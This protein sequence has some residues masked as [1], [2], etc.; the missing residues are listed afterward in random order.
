MLGGVQSE[1]DKE[2]TDLAFA[3]LGFAVGMLFMAT[4]VGGFT[5]VLSGSLLF[6]AQTN[7]Q[8]LPPDS[9]LFEMLKN[10]LRHALR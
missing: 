4:F 5:G 6:C 1:K 2:M 3:G 8:L 10:G 7:I 9:N